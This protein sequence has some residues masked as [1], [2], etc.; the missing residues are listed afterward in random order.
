MLTILLGKFTY[1]IQVF[2]EVTAP[3][4]TVSERVETVS[5]KKSL[6]KQS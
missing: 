6:Q 1:F 4:S 2:F 5:D 3:E